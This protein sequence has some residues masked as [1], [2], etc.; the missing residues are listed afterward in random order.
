[1]YQPPP[2]LADAGVTAP[3]VLLDLIM[4]MLNTDRSA[5]PSMAIIAAS[6][7]EP[8]IDPAVSMSR[9]GQAKPAQPEP[10][11]LSDHLPHAEGVPVDPD[12]DAGTM[13]MIGSSDAIAAKTETPQTPAVTSSSVTA[14]RVTAG[15]ASND[16]RPKYSSTRKHTDRL[17]LRCN[18]H[19]VHASSFSLRMVTS[20]GA[21]T[22]RHLSPFLS[23]WCAPSFQ[24]RS[25]AP[26]L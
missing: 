24:R 26:P 22:S 23:S 15:L 13:S 19:K 10:Y 25:V 11:Y 3:A 7:T 12:E 17:P 8:E 18:F 1:M 14:A 20:S 2:P 5:R 4:R 6:L 16:P 9:L 21:R